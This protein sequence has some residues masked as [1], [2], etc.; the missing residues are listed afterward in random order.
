MA[1]SLGERIRFVRE[2]R[3]MTQTELAEKI[4]LPSGENGRIRISQYE[5]GV[6]I[7]RPEL[8]EKI[9]EALGIKHLYL[10]GISTEKI[11]FLYT[12]F[13]RDRVNPVL[14]ENRGNGR[15]TLDFQSEEIY[16]YLHGWLNKKADLQE[17]KITEKEY[18]EWTI[19]LGPNNI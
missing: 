1:L 11:D 17:G 12:L 10:A 15:Y 6:H 18:I 7:P 3:G 9:S 13:E 4:G 8:L 2:F 14:I 16:A 19:N 5:N